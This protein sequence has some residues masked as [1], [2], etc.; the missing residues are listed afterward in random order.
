MTKKK[1][2][3]VS[4]SKPRLRVVTTW[5][6]APLTPDARAKIAEATVMGI[7]YIGSWAVNAFADMVANRVAKKLKKR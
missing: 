2:R 1:P 3:I 6:P 7:W 4:D 5:H